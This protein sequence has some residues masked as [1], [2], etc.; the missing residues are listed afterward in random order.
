MIQTKNINRDLITEMEIL[1]PEAFHIPEK[2]RRYR[3]ITISGIVILTVISLWKLQINPFTIFFGIGK[4]FQ[5]VMMFFPPTHGGWISEFIYAMGETLAMAFL[6]TLFGFLFAVPLGFLAAKNIIPSTIIH[7]VLRRFFDV[8]RGINTL[9][10]ALMFVNVAGLG[11]FAGIMAI[12]ITDT[13]TL[14]KLFAE[15]I[16]NV[17][18]SQIDGAKSTGAGPIQIIRYAFIPQ[19]LPIMLSNVLYFFESN[20]RAASILGILGAGGIGMQLY[21][22]IRIMNWPQVFFIIIMILITVAVIDTISKEIRKAIVANPE[23]RP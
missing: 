16:E 23:Y 4:F 13:A 9:I 7:I 8:I 2:Q 21:D 14:A 20:V 6:G 19:V 12:I 22:R 18:T 15:S 5:M 17:D 11:P 10:W 3:F 1:V